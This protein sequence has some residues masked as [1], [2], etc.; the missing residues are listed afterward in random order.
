M[1]GLKIAITGASGFVGANLVRYFN[2]SNEV[3]ALTRSTNPWR[4][5]KEFN[6]IKFD[7]KERQVVRDVLS[8]LKPDVLIH[9]AAYGGYHFETNVREIVETNVIGSINVLDASKGVPIVINVGSSSEYGIVDRPMNEEDLAA[10]VT[11]YAM[12]KTLQTELFHYGAHSITLRLFSVYGYYEEKHRLIPYIIY[13]TIKGR[14]PVLSNKNNV[15]DFVFIE[16]VADAFSRTIQKFEKIEKGTV[17]NVG[18]GVQMS[19][20]DVVKEMGIDTEWNSSVKAE[21]PERVWQADISKIKREL[22]WYPKHSL[23]EGLRK[24]R[25]WMEKN[26]E[27]YEM[28]DYDKFSRS[29]RSSNKT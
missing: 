17:F 7:V 5:N 15:R 14:K 10:P 4:L 22:N 13:S 23:S 16:D 2:P 6:L 21:E 1:E 27:L 3:Y 20:G 8:T 29:V 24:T 19:V 25:I 28:E 26:I 18:S 9:C 11:P 12:S